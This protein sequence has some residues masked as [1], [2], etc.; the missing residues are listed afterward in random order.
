MPQLTREA[1]LDAARQFE[2]PGITP[3]QAIVLAFAELAGTPL[4]PWN[5]DDAAVVCRAETLIH[6]GLGVRDAIATA[7][8]ELATWNQPK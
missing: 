6:D 7:R 8:K 2:K 3:D 1:L 5:L 4:D